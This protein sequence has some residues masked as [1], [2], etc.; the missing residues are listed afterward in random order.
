VINLD[1]RYYDTNLSREN[2]FVFT[3]DPNATPGGNANPII[4]P[5]GLRSNW[6]GG[7]FV[8]KLSIGL[9]DTMLSRRSSH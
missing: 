8:A 3:G 9:D 2:C 4:N 1:L 5:T 7:A 6:C